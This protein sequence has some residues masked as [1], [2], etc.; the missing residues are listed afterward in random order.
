MDKHDLTCVLEDVPYQKLDSTLRIIEDS[1]FTGKETINL[2]SLEHKALNKELLESAGASVWWDVKPFWCG[3]V[4]KQQKFRYSPKD[5]AYHLFVNSS[6]ELYW[7][8]KNEAVVPY[9]WGVNNGVIV[10][11]T[12]L[13]ISNFKSFWFN[14]SAVNVYQSLADELNKNKENKMELKEVSEKFGEVRITEY[15]NK[16]YTYIYHELL[17]LYRE[18]NDV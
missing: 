7:Q 4:Q 1:Q 14:L 15:K 11:E 10:F 5:E 13:E 16:D 6:D 17:G 2:V 12:D 9:E 8:R 18:S 3:E